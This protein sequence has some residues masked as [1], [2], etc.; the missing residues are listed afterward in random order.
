MN[1]A[2]LEQINQQRIWHWN[3]EPVSPLQIAIHLI[4]RVGAFVVALAVLAILWMVRQ[5]HWDC[6]ELRWLAL[7]LT[8]LLVVQ[9]A[10]GISVI[11]TGKAADIATAHVAVGALTLVTSFLLTLVL[12]KEE[13]LRHYDSLSLTAHGARGT[14]G[15]A[16]EEVTV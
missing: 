16:G 14:C 2:E 9:L 12:F 15:T 7:G 3:L 13:V 11:W 5:R 10:L 6:R 4:H 8:S 1:T